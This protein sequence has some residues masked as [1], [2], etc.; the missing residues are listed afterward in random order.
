[1]KT[2]VEWKRC[3]EDH[4]PVEVIKRCQIEE[5]VLSFCN[6]ALMN[7]N[8]PAKWSILNIV[9]IPKAGDMSSASNYRGISLS[10]VVSKLYNKM[11]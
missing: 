9:P 2:M 3:G 10:F 6:E 11:L 1:L 8:K 5:I 7:K 4:I